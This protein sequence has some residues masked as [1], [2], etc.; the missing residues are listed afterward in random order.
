MLLEI[1][2]TKKCDYLK[3]PCVFL[4]NE[5]FI[6]VFMVFLITCSCNIILKIE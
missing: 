1:P 4:E 3:V 6:E 2:T 5:D